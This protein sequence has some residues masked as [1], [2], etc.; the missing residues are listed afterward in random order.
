MLSSASVKLLL[1]FMKSDAPQACILMLQVWCLEDS[2]E[3]LLAS[4]GSTLVIVL[5]QTFWRVMKIAFEKQESGNLIASSSITVY[6]LYF[7][8]SLQTIDI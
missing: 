1:F 3:I 4:H 7:L 5:L 8:D 2:L 6:V